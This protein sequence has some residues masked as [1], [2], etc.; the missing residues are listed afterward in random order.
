MI[1][2]FTNEIFFIAS[3]P[4]ISTFLIQCKMLNLSSAM[5]ISLGPILSSMRGLTPLQMNGCCL[6]LSVRS[7]RGTLAW[8]NWLGADVTDVR[9]V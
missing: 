9:I 2:N 3:E 6:G 5:V 4:I 1:L 7:G 8:T